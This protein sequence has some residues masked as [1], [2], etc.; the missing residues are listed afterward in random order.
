MDRL[1]FQVLSKCGLTSE[2]NIINAEKA[3]LNNMTISNTYAFLMIAPWAFRVVSGMEHSAT[4]SRPDDTRVLLLHTLYKYRELYSETKYLPLLDRDGLLELQAMN[5]TR[6][7]HGLLKQLCVSYVDL[8]NQLCAIDEN[9]RKE[10]D[11]P[12]VH[13][14]V[15]LFH[16]SI[17]QFGHVSVFDELS[18]EAAHQ[19]LKRVLTQSKHKHGHLYSMRAV[20]ANEWRS[21]VGKVCAS[22][23]KDEELSD[24]QCQ[25]LVRGCF[26]D[27][28][29]IDSGLI[30]SLDV[31]HT[32]SP[33]MLKQFA[34]YAQ[35]P[36]NRRS[37][38]A[39][40]TVHKSAKM[41][42]RDVRSLSSMFRRNDGTVRSYLWNLLRH[43]ASNNQANDRSPDTFIVSFKCAI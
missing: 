5:D 11:K 39:V 2:Q 8:I 36:R 43:S 33:A 4:C 29:S 22:M 15:E 1:F 38:T 25:E 30:S 19:P 16:H 7:Y 26:G 21:R 24:D 40:W 42:G 18:F 10:I 28:S 14:V 32:F 20:L 9:I 31:R 23:L 27:S 13:R 37:L 41:K 34:E 35:G 12:N 17:S 3:R 6:E